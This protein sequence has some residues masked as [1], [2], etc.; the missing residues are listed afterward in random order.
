MAGHQRDDLE[1]PGEQGS[2]RHPALAEVVVDRRV[3][4]DD[5]L[6]SQLPGQRH[7]G[8]DVVVTVRD[9]GVG[10]P[11][12]GLETARAR[13]EAFDQADRHWQ[14]A[15]GAA[16]GGPSAGEDARDDGTAASQHEVR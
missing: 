5:P 7:D 15:D 1:G 6:Q 13:S 16:A 3:R 10:I 4:R 2:P 14:G 12:G 8:P 11:D 9:D